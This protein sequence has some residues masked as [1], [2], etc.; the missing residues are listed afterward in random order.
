[1]V[2]DYPL[3]AA[4]IKELL[5][6]E[7]FQEVEVAY[8]GAQALAKLAQ[9]KYSLV[10][11]DMKMPGMNG[12]ELLYAMRI[13]SHLQDTRFLMITGEK[14]ADFAAIKSA[15]VDAILVKPFTPETLRQKIESIFAETENQ[16][17]KPCSAGYL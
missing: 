5:R 15:G 3:V 12:V 11:S 10:I 1:M 6:T 7:G 14:S 2:D 17:R 9:R 13:I 16:S 8:G 4:T